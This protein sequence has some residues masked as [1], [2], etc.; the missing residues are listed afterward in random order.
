MST[1]WANPDH[2]NEFWRSGSFLRLDSERRQ[3]GAFWHQGVCSSLAFSPAPLHIK[4]ALQSNVLK[5]CVILMYVNEENTHVYLFYSGLHIC[6]PRAPDVFP[7]A[8]CSSRALSP[9]RRDSAKDLK[10]LFLRFVF[11]SIG[12]K[13]A[14]HRPLIYWYTHSFIQNK[15]WVVN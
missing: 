7:L 11:F 14:V 3:S 10:K 8:E 6:P 9:A 13:K 12:E 5:V 1:R 2:K 4:E 15:N